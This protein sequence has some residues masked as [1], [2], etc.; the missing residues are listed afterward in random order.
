M[1][2]SKPLLFVLSAFLA[3]TNAAPSSLDVRQADLSATIKL[4]TDAEFRGTCNSITVTPNQCIAFIGGLASLDKEVSS[5]VIRDA[6]SLDDMRSSRNPDVVRAVLDQKVNK[7]FDQKQARHSFG[8][9]RKNCASGPGFR[10]RHLCQVEMK[11]KKAADEITFADAC[12][13]VAQPESSELG[14]KPEDTEI[15]MESFTQDNTYYDFS[16]KEEKIT[17]SSCPSYTHRY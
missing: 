15:Q 13:R 1:F 14:D 12:A 17:S 10:G 8:W 7:G 9:L 4:C 3:T 6:F 16:I 5:A 11:T 2:T